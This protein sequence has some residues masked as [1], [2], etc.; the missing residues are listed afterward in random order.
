VFEFLGESIAPF[1][2]LIATG[3]VVCFFLAQRRVKRVGLFPPNN[4]VAMVWVAIGGFIGAHVLEVLAYYPE[5]LLQGPQTLFAIW[6]G[7]SSFGGFIGGTVGLFLYCRLRGLWML[8][9]IDAQL[10]GYVPGWIIA[11]G[12]CFV[13]HD[14][15][16]SRSDFVLA[17]AYPDG[18]RHNLGLYEVLV[19][20][21][22]TLVLYALPDR[23][24]FVGFHTALVLLL[25]APARFLLD[26]LRTGDRRYLGLTAAQYLCFVMLGLAVYL[27]IKGRARGDVEPAFTV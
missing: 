12:G 18:A 6:E 21:G 10:Y 26:L 23:K 3:M 13:S 27:I 24:R 5:R 16:G 20:A 4:A 17:V 11:R 1:T 7:F 2:W 15:L 22:I 9:Y 14:H 8:P 25:Y 19:V